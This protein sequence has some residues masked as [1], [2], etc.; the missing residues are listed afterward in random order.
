MAL[1]WVGFVDKNE[2]S[3]VYS[4]IRTS[5]IMA[6]VGS[7]EVPFSEIS[8]QGPR[9]KVKVIAFSPLPFAHRLEIAAAPP[10]R[11]KQSIGVQKTYWVGNCSTTLANRYH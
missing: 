6:R 3:V 4:P 1:A 9:T 5:K 2:N 7:I 10:W 8:P 11:P